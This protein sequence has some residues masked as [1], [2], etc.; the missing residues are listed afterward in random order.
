MCTNKFIQTQEQFADLVEKLRDI[1]KSEWTEEEILQAASEY[2]RYFNSGK[3][4]RTSHVDLSTPCTFHLRPDGTPRSPNSQKYQARKNLEEKVKKAKPYGAKW[5]VAHLCENSS[6]C[7][8]VCT[9][10]DH[11]YFATPKENHRDY[12]RLGNPTGAMKT[13]E[14]NRANKSGAFHDPHYMKIAQKLGGKAGSKSQLKNGTHNTQLKNMTC[15]YCFKKVT[16]ISVNRHELSCAKKL[17]V[18][19]HLPRPTRT[20]P[21][22]QEINL[23]NLHSDQ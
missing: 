18:A 15:R 12:D 21:N 17:G 5:H 9:N 11:L 20:D 6:G 2:A 10:P 7:D 23:N 3:D 1:H 13:V 22:P 19:S 16:A 4:V 14:T 8:A